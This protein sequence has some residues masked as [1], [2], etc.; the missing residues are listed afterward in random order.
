MTL[1]LSLGLVAMLAQGPGMT[2]TTV[3]VRPDTRLEMHLLGGDIVVHTWNRPAV[4]IEADLSERD[5]LN[6]DYSGAVLQVGAASRRGGPHSV[7]FTLTVPAAMDLTLSGTYSDITVDGTTGRVSLE[8][9]Q[10]DV[11]LHGGGG[12]VTVHSVSGDLNVSGVRGQL[13]AHST[14]GTVD[15]EDVTG[16]VNAETV[17]GDI[18][19]RGI[20]SDDVTA[21]T[22]NGDIE[23]R[24]AI[25]DNGQYRLSNHN[26]DVTVAV[27][28]GTNASVTVSTFNGD[29]DSDFPV[30]LAGGR[31]GKRFS[32]TLGTGSATLDLES[33]QGSIRL[34]R[35]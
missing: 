35:P 9:V 24:G 33:F 34:E 4:R 1:A 17:N 22:V 11:T 6:V 10:G 31:Q 26:G 30:T 12:L 28:V 8:T 14:N 20:R 21:T 16:S 25:R 27:P 3:A 15:A 19:L 5:R 18:K 23:Y 2:D 13:D 32:F 29:F 7:D